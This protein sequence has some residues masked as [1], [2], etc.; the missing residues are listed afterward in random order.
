MKIKKF[1]SFLCSNFREITNLDH[2]F[3]T[4]LV[5]ASDLSLSLLL[6]PPDA[7][8]FK[9][10]TKEILIFLYLKNKIRKGI[11]KNEFVFF[12]E[13]ITIEYLFGNTALNGKI[14]IMLFIGT[15][16]V[17]PRA[18]I[19]SGSGFIGF[20]NFSKVRVWVNRVSLLK[21]GFSG[22]LGLFFDFTKWC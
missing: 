3:M 13:I 5:W 7:E 17:P 14:Q 21:F 4:F 15:I 1:L 20:S 22:L 10:Y 18:Q 12:F 9:W 16:L 11:R 8:S 19:S 6:T 2:V